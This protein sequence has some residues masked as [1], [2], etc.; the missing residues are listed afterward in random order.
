M[1]PSSGEST[2][3]GGGVGSGVVVFAS[4]AAPVRPLDGRSVSG[5][6]RRS[7][8]GR[9][10]RA[11]RRA[12]TS[13][14]SGGG[15]REGWRWEG[16]SEVAHPAGGRRAQPEDPLPEEHEGDDDGR[17]TPT[18]DFDG[19]VEE[20]FSGFCGCCLSV[21]RSFRHL[22]APKDKPC[23]YPAFVEPTAGLEPATPSLRG[24]GRAKTADIS[25]H[26]WTGF[27]LQMGLIGM[28]TR[29]RP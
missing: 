20:P 1:S 5:S 17:R 19:T 6:R 11:A 8:R 18:S 2:S 4:S 29:E 16:R 23:I 14:T 28:S 24:M 13:T 9:R 27:S 3:S 22:A 21:A 15:L 12:P 10:N 26:R 7:R 25:A